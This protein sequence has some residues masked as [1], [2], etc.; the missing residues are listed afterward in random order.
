MMLSLQY[1]ILTTGFVD[2]I[3]N[4]SRSS[5]K[6]LGTVVN[7][8]TSMKEMLTDCDVSTLTNLMRA[9]D[10]LLRPIIIEQGVHYEIWRDF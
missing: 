7:W 2:L 9:V 4:S 8:L 5:M 6:H 1:R 10:V 3:V